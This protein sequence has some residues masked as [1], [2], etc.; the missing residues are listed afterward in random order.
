M[1]RTVKQCWI[2]PNFSYVGIGRSCAGYPSVCAVSSLSPARLGVLICARQC[3]VAIGAS[4][5]FSAC[6]AALLASFLADLPEVLLEPLYFGIG[7][8]RRFVV[9]FLRMSFR[10]HTRPNH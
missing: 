6:A 4:G 8:T 3:S 9:F 1:T 10:F 5:F 2:E 7:C